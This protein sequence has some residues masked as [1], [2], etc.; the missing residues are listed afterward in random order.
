MWCSAAGEQGLMTQLAHRQVKVP[1]VAL[2]AHEAVAVQLD[3][4]QQ[5]DSPW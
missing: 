1:E 5:N 4:L 3:A 2:S